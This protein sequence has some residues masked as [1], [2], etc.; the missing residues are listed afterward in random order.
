MKGDE[1]IPVI[2]GRCLIA[3]EGP[4]NALTGR[5]VAT[6]LQEQLGIKLEKTTGP[7][8]F[9]IVDRMEKSPTEN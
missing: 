5:R 4:A 2:D 1:F 3:R 8:E 9:L 7:V 6:A